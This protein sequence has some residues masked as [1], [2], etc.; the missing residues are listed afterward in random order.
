M[1]R[2]QVAEEAGLEH[3][4]GEGE[5]GGAGTAGDIEAGV[6]GSP[7][8]GDLEEGVAEVERRPGDDTPT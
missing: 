8:G 4:G 2:E 5:R 3:T 7:A 6:P 1:D